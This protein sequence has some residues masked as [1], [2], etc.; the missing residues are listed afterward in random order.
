MS[1]LQ[2]IDYD[3]KGQKRAFDLSGVDLL[4]GPNGSGKTTALL[5]IIAGL[6][7]L[8]ESPGDLVRPYI[9]PDREGSV[10]LVFDTGTVVRDLSETRT[11]AALKAGIEAERIAGEHL[12]RWDLADFATA[13]ESAREALLRRVLG[14]R[15]A[16]D[17]ALPENPL[18]TELLKAVPLAGDAGAWLDKAIGWTR[19]EYT[20]ANAANKVAIQGAEAA[21]QA[22]QDAPPGM[23]STAKASAEDLERQILG[24]RA[25]AASAKRE[26]EAAAKAEERR[27][28]AAKRYAE[29]EE[30][31]R[32][33]E[34]FLTSPLPAPIDIGALEKVHAEARAEL[35]AARATEKPLRA[36]FGAAVSVRHHAEASLTALESL[37]AKAP[38]C[39]HCGGADPLLLAPQIASVREAL[40]AAGWAV[41]DAEA[42]LAIAE[43]KAGNASEA[44]VAAD[45]ALSA[46]ISADARRISLGRERADK[47]ARKAEIEADLERL[48]EDIQAPAVAPASFGGAELLASLEEE[49]A[50]AR[51]TIDLHTRHAE[52]GRLH[53]EAIAKRAKAAERFEAVKKLGE[54]LK[55]LQAAEAER[56]FSPLTATT[57]DLLAQMRSPFRLQ[58]NSAAD[59][60]ATDSRR[61]GAYVA[62]WALSDAERACVGAAMALALVRLSKSPWPALVMDGL[63]RMDVG[64]LC[65][66]L[67]GVRSAF[68]AGWLANFVG[69]IVAAS[70][71]ENQHEGMTFHWMGGK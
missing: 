57:N 62:F 18:R 2:R 51:K 22:L 12:V 69:A 29:L 6:R 25:E 67:E 65:D 46:A 20:T 50:A 61:G 41:E 9:G 63:E 37:A 66:F 3:L 31:L 8:A 71:R 68:A 35:E 40:Q 42:D 17:L 19:A 5:A 45:R 16:S 28:R 58:V 70:K 11:K 15:S 24:L 27:Q 1:I 55:A 14:S 53:Q 26:A 34:S 33:L 23:L 54:A 52:R 7:G 4:V 10:E 64:T 21:Q 48:K 56:A 43:R 47:A 38:L 13:T 44:L 39:A 36:A 32:D 59:F 49:L 60:G 30:Q